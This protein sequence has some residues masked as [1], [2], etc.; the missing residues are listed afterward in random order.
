[1]KQQKIIIEVNGPTFIAFDGEKEVEVTKSEFEKL[2]LELPEK[3]IIAI[4]IKQKDYSKLNNTILAEECTK[5]NLDISECKIKK[6][7]VA[8]LEADDLSKEV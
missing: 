8:L 2:P 7:Y 6:D 5:R 4:E 3:E 1:M